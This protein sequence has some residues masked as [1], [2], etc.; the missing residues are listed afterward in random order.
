MVATHQLLISM[1]VEANTPTPIKFI[2]PRDRWWPVIKGFDALQYPG[3][4]VTTNL[5]L[6]LTVIVILRLPPGR[7]RHLSPEQ[8]HILQ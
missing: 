7:E 4:D 5:S 6:R 1:Q 2:K 3:P 8:V